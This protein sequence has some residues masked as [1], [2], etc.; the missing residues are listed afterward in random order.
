VRVF[1][2]VFVSNGLN[3]PVDVLVV[4]WH[5]MIQCETS[6]IT[7]IFLCCTPSTTVPG[8]AGVANVFVIP[9]PCHV[10][11]FLTTKTSYGLRAVLRACPFKKKIIQVSKLSN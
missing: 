9:F 3:L 2:L 1:V 10:S 8:P 11:S 6:E 5:K 7:M 4:S